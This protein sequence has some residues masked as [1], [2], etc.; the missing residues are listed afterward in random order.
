MKKRC[1]PTNNAISIHSPV[2]CPEL[3]I[4]CIVDPESP[5]GPVDPEL[6]EDDL[7]PELPEV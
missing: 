4:P 1:I 5:A 2:L 3:I 6:P 7:D